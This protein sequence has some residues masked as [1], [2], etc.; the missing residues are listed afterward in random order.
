MMSKPPTLAE[1]A[2]GG[3]ENIVGAA[4]DR[5][6]ALLAE[7]RALLEATAAELLEKETLGE[8]EL[9]RLKEALQS[10]PT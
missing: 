4:F 8:P 6:V 9:Q 3:V 1:P 5:A 10:S 2:V 7:R